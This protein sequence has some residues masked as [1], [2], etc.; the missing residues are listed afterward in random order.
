MKSDIVSYLIIALCAGC[1]F[2]AQQH[3]QIPANPLIAVPDSLQHINF[4]T[5]VITTGLVLPAH[6]ATNMVV[7]PDQGTIIINSLVSIE[8]NASLT[9]QPGTTLAVSEFGG[10]N[11]FG[12][13]YAV[14]TTNKPISFITNELNET[15]RHW[16]GILLQDFST[17]H[18]SNVS[19]H[20]ASPAISCSG[21]A[22]TSIQHITFL[23]DAVGNARNTANCTIQ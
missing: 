22:K 18:I 16:V 20:H 6:I 15:N 10:L 2:F 19:I 5:P 7:G 17:S 11:V 12:S 9:I 13:L 14:G 23:L 1:V 8:K 4:H 3:I 21:Q